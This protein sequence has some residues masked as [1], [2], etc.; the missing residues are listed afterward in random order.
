MFDS[1]YWN[2]LNQV[3][4]KI[5]N[6]SRNPLYYKTIKNC[7][8][9]ILVT[10]YFNLEW[11]KVFQALYIIHMHNAQHT[12]PETFILEILPYY[13]ANLISFECI[14]SRYWIIRGI[15]NSF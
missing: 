1:T 9:S 8:K 7:W 15:Q 6:A 12:T 5:Y 2:G 11:K 3:N 14:S 13:L 4:Q 10:I